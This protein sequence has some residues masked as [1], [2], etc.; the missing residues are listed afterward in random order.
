MVRQPPNTN[1][2]MKLGIMKYNSKV[3][4]QMNQLVELGFADI[5]GKARAMSFLGL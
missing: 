2:F 3:M 5:I 4:P 1:I